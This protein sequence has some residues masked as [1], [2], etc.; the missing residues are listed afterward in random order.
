MTV[1]E[2]IRDKLTLALAPLR[3]IITD[4]S[5]RHAGHAGHRPEGETHFEVEI[6]AAAFEGKSRL[7][8]QRLVYD[9]LAAELSGPVHALALKTLTPEQASAASGG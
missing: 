1:A 8:R 5:H 3:L 6:V 7:E 4:D 9:T 2:T